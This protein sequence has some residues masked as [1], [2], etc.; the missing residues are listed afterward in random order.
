MRK[1]LFF[2]FHLLL[3]LSAFTQSLHGKIIDNKNKPLA[4]ASV[5]LVGTSTTTTT[6]AKGLFSIN[7]QNTTYKKLVLSHV[8]FNTDTL[9]LTNDSFIV[10]Q[11]TETK[12]LKE[13]TITAK[14]ADN[15]IAT[16]NPIKTEVITAKELTKGA[17]CD[18]A[19]CFGSNASVSPTTTNIV[20]N[21]QELRILGLSGVYNQTL[22]DGLP[23]IQGL[24]FTYGISSIPGLF[25]DNIYVAK[26]TTSV[27]QGYESISGQINVEPKEPGKADKLLLNLYVNSFSEKHLNAIY[28]NPIGKR[29]LWQNIVAFHTVQPAN[30]IDKDGDTFL[31]VPL[32]TRYLFYDKV[33]YRDD[34]SF[35]WSSRIGFMYL[36]EQRIGGQTTFNPSTDKGSSTIYGQTVNI[37]QPTIYTK[38]GYR[39]NDDK[40]ITFLS[41][42]FSQQQNAWF[43]QTKYDA[44][45]HNLYCNLQYELKW[46]E[47]HDF[48]TGLSLRNN[49]LEENISF[50]ANPLNKTF[51]GNYLKNETVTGL[52]AENIFNWNDYKYQLITGIRFDHHNTFGNFFTPRAMFKISPYQKTTLRA[53]IGTGWRTANIFSE[54]INLLSSQRNIIFLETLKPEQALNYGFNIVQRFEN[55]ILSGSISADFYRTQF[56]N[57]IFPDYDTDPTKA[58]ISN[59]TGTSISNGFQTDLNLTFFKTLSTKISYN[60]LDVFRNVNGNKINLPFNSLHKILATISYKPLN[61]LWHIDLN[62]HWFGVQVLPNT[63]ALPQD[64]QRS[65]KSKPYATTN[66]QFTYNLKKI[67][68]Y[69]GCENLF[70][71][72]QQQPIISWQNPFSPYFDTSSVWGPTR[73]RELY[74]GIRYRLK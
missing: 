17:C 25:I 26:G 48:K 74:C 67:E 40:A 52:F 21:S 51:A 59:F 53:S 34:K 10:H 57:Q 18:L 24:S 16:I 56:Q 35:G 28:A 36:N 39:F 55:N 69:A 62:F 23:L 71:Y 61:E 11:L 2:F 46:R 54:N 50:S 29:K 9:L 27:I 37:Q 13:V 41:D 19:G 38:T 70:D 20:T 68:L 33:K 7:L 32:L 30:K 12:S 22:L 73:G 8:G 42:F 43:G 63:S 15:Y 47:K 31:D 6:D 66:L 58:Y 5:Y 4:G 60:Y 45:Q 1:L 49:N 65:D 14:R 72:R 3:P 64:L 44:T